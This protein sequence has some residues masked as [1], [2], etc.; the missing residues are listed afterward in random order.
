MSLSHVNLYISK[1]FHSQ[2]SSIP[3]AKLYRG[4]QVCGLPAI[5]IGTIFRFFKV[6][7]S[8]WVFPPKRE[9]TIIFEKQLRRGNKK[10]STCP[11]P[12]E[13]LPNKPSSKPKYILKCAW[14]CFC[15]NFIGIDGNQYT[16][17]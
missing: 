11:T 6:I 14:L 7:A 4:L 16:H 12:V 8:K 3:T 17:W 2:P 9:S 13:K 10:P 1:T 15:S 5:M